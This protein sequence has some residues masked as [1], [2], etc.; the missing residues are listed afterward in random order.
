[1]AAATISDAISCG[2]LDVGDVRQNG[3][4]R[5]ADTNKRKAVAVER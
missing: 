5:Y 4:G 1:L 3:K 2:C